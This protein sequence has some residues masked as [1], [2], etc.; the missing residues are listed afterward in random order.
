MGAW[1]IT[2]RDG[3][4]QD[5]AH[6]SPSHELTATDDYYTR[7][8]Q[9]LTD[10]GLLAVR[11]A[12]V[13]VGQ[14]WDDHEIANDMW[15]DGAENHDDEEDGISWA[16]RK[17]NGLEAWLD[18]MPVRGTTV[19]YRASHFGAAE[20]VSMNTRWG[21]ENID[22]GEPQYE[23]AL[24]SLHDP[25][26]WKGE[27]GEYSSPWTDPARAGGVAVARAQML[28]ILESRQAFSEEQLQWIL[29]KIGGSSAANVILLSGT[30]A[31]SNMWNYGD[32]TLAGT[33]FE[34]LLKMVATG[35]PDFR[36]VLY[37]TAGK[38]TTDILFA[39]LYGLYRGSDTLAQAQ[40]QL[41]QLISAC[42]AR[43]NGGKCTIL[44]GD[45]HNGYITQHSERVAELTSPSVSAIGLVQNFVTSLPNGFA[46]IPGAIASSTGFDMLNMLQS[47]EA[48]D[49]ASA[50]A[51]SQALGGALYSG[52]PA[53]IGSTWGEIAAAAPY[54]KVVAQDVA[55]NGFGVTHCTAAGCS[56][57]IRGLPIGCL[58]T[59][60]PIEAIGCVFNDVHTV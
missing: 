21:S 16:A 41:Q 8:K 11:A 40:G 33:S 10:G 39:I 26:L 1:N 42:D 27:D 12:G 36:S 15:G 57:T 53:T 5:P 50:L 32:I 34:P 43:P 55:H 24:W 14:V 37:G 19:G 28:A 20:V 7:Y 51:N 38:G 45:V 22:I 52:D 29:N 3:N 30:Q 35:T 17:A 46:D 9:Y 58:S 2:A 44:S 18:Y 31:L 23:E 48:G 60:T 4:D 13:N 54:P 49:L 56:Y 59:P 6:F 25:A 47:R